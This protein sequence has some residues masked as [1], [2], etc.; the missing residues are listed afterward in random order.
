MPTRTYTDFFKFYELGKSENTA[1]LMSELRKLAT[2]PQDNYLK[3]WT[4]QMFA[5]NPSV[6]VPMIAAELKNLKTYPYIFYRTL[7]FAAT[8]EAIEILKNQS[9]KIN[10]WF[11]AESIVASLTLAGDAGKNALSE[12]ENQRLPENMKLAIQKYKSGELNAKNYE[13]VKF[14]PLSK[15]ELPDNF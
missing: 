7:G 1:A 2:S 3:D 6:S 10:G 4:A 12:L 15:S 14:A 8:P 9:A 13:E 5:K 11:D